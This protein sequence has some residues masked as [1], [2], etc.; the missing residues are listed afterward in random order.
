QCLP[1][2]LVI[3]VSRLQQFVRFLLFKV[4]N[5]ELVSIHFCNHGAIVLASCNRTGE[6]HNCESEENSRDGNPYRNIS[7][8]VISSNFLDSWVRQARRHFHTS[9]RSYLEHLISS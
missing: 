7:L 9:P 2:R 5:R 1:F 8:H 4:G 3:L 6:N